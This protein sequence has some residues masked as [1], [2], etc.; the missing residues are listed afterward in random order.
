MT[1]VENLAYPARLGLKTAEFEK[2]YE[3]SKNYYL[4]KKTDSALTAC[5]R[6]QE[7]HEQVKADNT[8]LTKILGVKAY[9]TF[10]KYM[11]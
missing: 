8:T 9:E 3:N 5:Q 11:R 6:A 7:K 4:A 2:I 10:L 1:E